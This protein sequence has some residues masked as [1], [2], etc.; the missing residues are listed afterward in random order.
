ME[1]T[2]ASENILVS[3]RR[4][5]RAIYL[6]SR[7]LESRFKLTVPQLVCLR[8]LETNGPQAPGKLAGH[9][10]LSQA[11]VTGIINRL[12]LR[13]LVSRERKEADRR[14]VTVSLT[15]KG[16]QVVRHAPSPLQDRFIERLTSLP[17]EEQDLINQVLEKVVTMMEAHDLE[18]APIMSTTGRWEI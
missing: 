1:L 3:L 9:V 16:Q 18:A 13:G 8:Y 17:Q 4:I 15:E 7:D 5:T 10:F 11:T 6:H 14:R 2:P 12:E